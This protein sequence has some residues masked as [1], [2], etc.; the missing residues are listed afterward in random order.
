MSNYDLI[1]KCC[2]DLLYNFPEAK[3]TLYYI[4]QRLPEAAIKQF[5]FGYFP[6]NEYLDVLASA[7]GDDLLNSYDFIYDSIY[8]GEKYRCSI[9]ADYN[10]ILPYK[11]LYGNVIGIV[12]RSILS[13]KE[14]ENT[15]ISK[16]KNTSFP[17][18]NHLFGLDIAKKYIIKNNLAIVAEGQLD[19]I[20]SYN[21]GLKNVVALGSSSMSFEQLLLLL[22]YTNNIIL[23]LDNDDAGKEGEEKIMKNY[24]KY[25]NIRKAFLPEGYK[26][27]DQFFAL[28]EMKDFQLKFNI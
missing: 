28:N 8:N 13:D 18:R 23:I 6:P 25:A 17:K 19:I 11:D 4:S 22:R 3:E 24:G 7:V 2:S 14:R 27:L 10:L 15:N 21:K 16:Y 5:Q 26:D 1:I 12:G 20:Q 9:M